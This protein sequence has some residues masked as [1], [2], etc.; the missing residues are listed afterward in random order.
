MNSEVLKDRM[1]YSTEN[2]YEYIQKQK[3]SCIGVVYT[4]K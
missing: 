2:T 1:L 4:K 3:K